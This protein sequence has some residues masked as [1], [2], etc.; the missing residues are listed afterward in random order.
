MLAKVI[1]DI[2]V[3]QVNR[4]FDYLVPE[5]WEEAIQLGMRVEV[6]FGP[7]QLLGFVVGFSDE[8]SF[9]GTLKPISKLLDYRSFLNEELIELSDYL[10]NHLQAFRIAVLQTMLPNLLKVKYESDFLIH[11]HAQIQA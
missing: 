9:T 10:A 8:T 1:I 6:P 7:R 5:Q 2:P 4:E 11:N 3:A